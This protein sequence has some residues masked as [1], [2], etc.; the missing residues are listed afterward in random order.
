VWAKA[1][2]VAALQQFDRATREPESQRVL[3]AFMRVLDACRTPRAN[4]YPPGLIRGLIRDFLLSNGRESYSGMRPE[5]LRF[6]VR[7]AIDP[8]E[9]IEA[10]AADTALGPRALIEHLRTDPT[11]RLVWRTVHALSG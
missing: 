1:D 9:L 10:C 11:L 3:A 8:H 2:P 6:L 5:L 4:T 7:E